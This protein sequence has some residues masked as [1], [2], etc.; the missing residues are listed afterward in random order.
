MAS[1]GKKFT[2]G[3]L[4]RGQAGKTLKAQIVLVFVF[5]M[6]AQSIVVGVVGMMQFNDSI[7]KVSGMGRGRR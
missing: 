2:G 4:Q 6:L 1:K 7:Q 3:K 5:V